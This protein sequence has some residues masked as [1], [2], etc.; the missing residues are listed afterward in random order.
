MTAKYLTPKPP[1]PA[2]VNNFGFEPPLNKDLEDLESSYSSLYINSEDYE[3]MNTTSKPINSRNTSLNVCVKTV[4]PTRPIHTVS[5][6]KDRQKM[7]HS[8]VL[9]KA[10]FEKRGEF[11]FERKKELTK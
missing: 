6:T 11:W 3:E 4:Q 10:E 2:T 7:E 9:N 1:K 5:N 8:F